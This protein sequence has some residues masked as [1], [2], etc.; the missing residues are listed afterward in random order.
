MIGVGACSP[1]SEES[2]S[3]EESPS[4]EGSPSSSAVSG[5]S[6]GLESDSEAD[7]PTMS[8][9]EQA[10]ADS[11]ERY[12]LRLSIWLTSQGVETD[13]MDNPMVGTWA[14]DDGSGLFVFTDSEFTWYKDED[15]LDDNY[16]KGTYYV[17][18]GA[19]TYSGF[20]L[21]KGEGWEAYSVFL[22]YTA[23]R[24]EGADQATNYNGLFMVERQGS[25]DVFYINNQRTGGEYT[26]TRVES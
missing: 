5:S 18:P 12:G 17:L 4:L 9:E 6:D 1:G 24:A 10:T 19:E 2:P 25:P 23:T 8:P 21:D 11:F 3:V 15:D 22:H 20:V 14:V 7:L 13:D 16:Y 26:V